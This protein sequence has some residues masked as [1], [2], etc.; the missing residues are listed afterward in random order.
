MVNLPLEISEKIES[1]PRKDDEQIEVSYSILYGDK[2][3]YNELIQEVSVAVN[4]QL[5]LD[6]QHLP[7]IDPVDFDIS[8][9]Q[10]KLFIYGPSGSGKSRLIFEIMKDKRQ[11][12]QGLIEKVYIINPRQRIGEKTGRTNLINLINQFTENDIV[13]WDNFPDDLIKR[14]IDN[15]RRALEIISSK[16][17]RSLLVALKPKYLEVYRGIN[18]KIPELFGYGISYNKEKIKNMIKSYGNNISALQFLLKNILERILTK[19]RIFCGK[20]SLSHSL[21][22]TILKNS[23]GKYK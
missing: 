22:L 16:E 17:V 5:S 13:V 2:R 7:F 11:Q 8:R 3:N 12:L 21:S 9:Y 6:D 20:R 19:Y 14:D 10:D 18:N 1:I 4:L 15:A 23:I